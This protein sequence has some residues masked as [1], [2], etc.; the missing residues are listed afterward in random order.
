MASPLASHTCAVEILFSFYHSVAL[1]PASHRG[2]L[3]GLYSIEW[4]HIPG[5]FFYFV[6]Q[7]LAGA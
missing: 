7:N 3:G 6:W 5:D 4:R 2:A 1:V